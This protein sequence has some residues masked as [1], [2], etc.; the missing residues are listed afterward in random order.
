MAVLQDILPKD[1][2]E[3]IDM[4][5]RLP[6]V[7]KKEVVAPAVS[8]KEAVQD[9]SEL[10][11]NPPFFVSSWIVASALHCLRKLNDKNGLPAVCKCLKSTDALVLE[12]AVKALA[13]L[14]SNTQEAHRILLSVPTSRLV[15]LPLESLLKN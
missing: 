13:R 7:R 3:T 11:L 2:F 15:N 8:E 6:F 10:V 1:L 14:E 9:V 5:A 4:V 12:T